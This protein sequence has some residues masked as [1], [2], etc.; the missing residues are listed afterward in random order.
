MNITLFTA[1][2]VAFAAVTSLCAEAAKK[3]LD[4]LGVQYASNILVTALS[5]IIGTVGTGIYYI[6]F[7]VEFNLINIVCMPL[8]GL[9]TAIGAMVG[10]DKVIQTIKQLGFKN[11]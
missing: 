10:Y 9:A 4:E 8:M 6:L 11:E 5:L 1:L 7:S 2:L 3:L